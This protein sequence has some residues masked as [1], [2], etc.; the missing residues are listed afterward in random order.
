MSMKALQSGHLLSV[1]FPP[2]CTFEH[3]LS[4]ESELKLSAAA[5]AGTQRT[6]LLKKCFTSLMEASVSLKEA[7]GE[8]EE[9]GDDQDAE[10]QEEFLDQC[11]KVAV[12]L[13]N[14]TVVEEGI[15][16]TKSKS[17]N[18]RLI[19]RVLYSLLYG[20]TPSS[21]TRTLIAST[22]HLQLPQHLPC[23]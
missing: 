3:G 13:E 1:L 7:Q 12:A 18:W 8:K 19:N 23:M 11:A 21:A 17:L 20:G 2:A 14:G 5:D 15:W 10:T 9:S 16:T 4:S 6:D 22:S